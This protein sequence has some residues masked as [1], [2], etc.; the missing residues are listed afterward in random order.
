MSSGFITDD[1]SEKT[2]ERTGR[3]DRRQR[4][5]ASL[6]GFRF[7]RHGDVHR[8]VD[9]HL[10]TDRRTRPALKTLLP[11]AHGSHENR[12]K[13]IVLALCQRAV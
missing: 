3:T 9:T 13:A 12:R 1:G 6:I 4:T 7:A 5:E 2:D 11:L 10:Q 8:P